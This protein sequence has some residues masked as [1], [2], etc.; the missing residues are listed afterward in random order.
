MKMAVLMSKIEVFL[1]VDETGAATSLQEAAGGL[2]GAVDEVVL[3]FSSMRRID[4]CDLRAL[5]EFAQV[6]DEKA[7]SIVLRS[8]N[9]DVYKVLKLLKLTSRFSFVN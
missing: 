6:A 2:N 7:V 4:S 9:V 1:N 3:D 5:E 8:V